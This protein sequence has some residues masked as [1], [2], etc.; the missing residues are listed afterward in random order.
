MP[1]RIT[2]VLGV[3]GSLVPTVSVAGPRA[4]GAEG[5]NRTVST[6][7]LPA[8]IETGRPGAPT[9][10]KSPAF[11]PLMLRE[12]ALS[13]H[14]PVSPMVI[15][16]SAVCG[17]V[18]SS[19]ATPPKSSAL[20]LMVTCAAPLVPVI[21][22]ES[23]GLTGSL[24]ETISD[25][26][27]GPDD[28]PAA[29]RTVNVRLSPTG[30]VC[31]SA[32][33][34]STERPG[35]LPPAIATL[36]I[37]SGARPVLV[38]VTNW[39]AG[40]PEQTTLKFSDPLNTALGKPMVP[41]TATDWVSK[42]IW[43]VSMITDVVSGPAEAALALGENFTFTKASSLGRSVPHRGDAGSMTKALGAPGARRTFRRFRSPAAMLRMVM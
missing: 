23:V 18:R 31:G 6:R 26:E 5:L 30:S 13:P 16:R 7:L 19:V 28:E 10:E 25:P 14:D 3:T 15:V 42:P 34:V 36:E 21:G 17:A 11:A 35:V 2:G 33:G 12:V 32:G 9:S 4:P 41:D 20:E 43:S 29:K 39:S 8:L 1:V 24:V 27:I 22:I 38:T 40:V 37:V